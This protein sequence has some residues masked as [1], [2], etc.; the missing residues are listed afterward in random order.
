MNGVRAWTCGG[1]RPVLALHCSLSHSGAWS[2]LVGHL[3]GVTVTARDLPGHGR[4][5]EWDGK[6]DLH[7]LATRCALTLAEGIGGGAPVDLLGHSF[8]ATVALRIAL[9]RPELVRSLTLIEPVLFAAA[10]AAGWPGWAVFEQEGQEM[11]CLLASGDREGATRVFLADWGAAVPFDDLPAA[12]R[13][14]MTDRIHL[15]PAQDDTLLRDAAGLLGFMRPEGL[16]LPVLLV[17]GADSPPVMA[18]ILDELARRLPDT[19]RLVVPGAGHMVPIT[20][21]EPVARA[22]MALLAES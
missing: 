20:H 12:L 22:I 21:P 16:G 2:G 8:G 9:E 14:Y 18:A 1:S 3:A 5:P 17:E 11:R 4:A 15:I 6:T 13:K 7:T 10:R 19:R